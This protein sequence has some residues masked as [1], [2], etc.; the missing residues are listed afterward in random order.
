MNERLAEIG[1]RIG[2]VRKLGSVVSAMRG[3]AAA[4]A[5]QAQ[6][7]LTAI[8][9][10][11][12]TIHRAVAR[13]LAMASEPAPAPQ[14][15]D[16]CVVFLAEQGF[17]GAFSEHVLD[18]L[19]AAPRLV[20]VGTRGHAIAV[21]SGLMPWRHLALPVH[22]PGVPRF[23]DGLARDLMASGS[24]RIEAVFPAVAPDTTVEV[25]RLPIFPVEAT[26]DDRAAPPP[27]LN[28]APADLLAGLMAEALHAGL[29]R[30]ALHA[31]TAENV[32]RMQAM[33][34]AQTQ[35]ERKLAELVALERQVRQET[36]TAEIIELAS[37]EGAFRSRLR[38][39]DAARRRLDPPS[40]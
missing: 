23:A 5:R 12:A 4:R 36:I 25:R 40:P 31:L 11:E 39:L 38:R 21:E 37:G 15:P 27:I 3:I 30:A 16:T 28:L 18:R 2:G 8:D 33:A 34:A 32:A 13:V 9:A 29:C 20:V 26:P 14:A 22:G 1:A 6:D 35:T 19:G 17:A 7:E 24:R 10:Y